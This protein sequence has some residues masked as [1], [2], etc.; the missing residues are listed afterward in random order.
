MGL[1]K[2]LSN[3]VRAKKM[4]AE[5]ALK[6]PERDIKLAIIDSRKQASEFQAKISGLNMQ[7]KLLER[8]LT[9]KKASSKKKGEMAEKAVEAGNDDDAKTLLESQ[10]RIDTES[11]SLQTQIVQNKKDLGNARKQ[12]QSMQSKIKDAEMNEGRLKMRLESAKVR[13]GLAQASSS[14]NSGDNPLSALNSLSDAVNEAEAS[15]EAT[16]EEVGLESANVEASME[17]KYGSDSSSG[18]TDKLAALKAAAKKKK[19]KAKA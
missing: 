16:E 8:Q 12:L 18:V 10:E 5:E 13:E 6:D 19:T 2:T 17:D 7:N 3:I 15:A 4:A 1:F 11:K 14:I 9:E